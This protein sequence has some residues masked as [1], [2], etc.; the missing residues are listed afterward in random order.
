[1]L[2]A[3]KK[4]VIISGFCI[5]LL[6][7]ALFAAGCTLSPGGKVTPTPVPTPVPTIAPVETP[8]VSTC[9][10]TTC[11]GLDL[12]CGTNV[13]QV[14]TMEYQIGDKCRNLASCDS[15]GGSCTLVTG[16]KYVACKACVEKCQAA[17][18]PDG[19]AAFSCAEKC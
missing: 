4:P 9:G 18:G 3:M 10:F 12:A 8:D 13:P 7:A 16:P 6:I 15:S 5:V 19:L 17:A 1:M 11:H 14:C 2:S